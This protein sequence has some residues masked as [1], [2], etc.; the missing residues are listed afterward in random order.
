MSDKRKQRRVRDGGSEP[1]P[2]TE[3]DAAEFAY[4]NN[5]DIGGT[6][7]SSEQKEDIAP[8]IDEVAKVLEK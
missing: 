4:Q 8:L 2:Y 1:I 3:P 6:P 5:Y 7:K